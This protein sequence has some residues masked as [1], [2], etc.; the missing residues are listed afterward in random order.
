MVDPGKRRDYLD[1]FI[2]LLLKSLNTLVG[3]GRLQNFIV[4]ARVGDH[5][6]G[7]ISFLLAKLSEVPIVPGI[8]SF[9]QDRRGRWGGAGK[10][11]CSVLSRASS[12]PEKDVHL[13]NSVSSV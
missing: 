6:K 10:R 3:T 8:P 9:W 12:S 5:Q 11:S 1:R 2:H 7:E 4:L 13:Q